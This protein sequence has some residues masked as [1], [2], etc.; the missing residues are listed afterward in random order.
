[1]IGSLFADG[2]HERI[3]VIGAGPKRA[4][5]GRIPEC[6]L[7]AYLANNCASLALL[8]GVGNDLRIC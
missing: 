6:G 1:M 5:A 3:A 2:D 7:V 4:A 8:H